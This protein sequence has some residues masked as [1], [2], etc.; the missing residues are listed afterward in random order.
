MSAGFGGGGGTIKVRALKHNIQSSALQTT[1]ETKN[2][3]LIYSSRQPNES[4]SVFECALNSA[5]LS[6]T[7]KVDKRIPVTS[8]FTETLEERRDAKDVGLKV[9]TNQLSEA[10]GMAELDD[11]TNTDNTDFQCDEALRSR[12]RGIATMNQSK[13]TKLMTEKKFKD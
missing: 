9:N 13:K 1:D 8:A 4:A 10:V 11:F 2:N 6:S 3:Q 12:N 5:E 7:I